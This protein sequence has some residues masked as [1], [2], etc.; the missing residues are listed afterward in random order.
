MAS[1]TS[2]DFE[3]EASVSW[4]LQSSVSFISYWL[5]FIRH[6]AS[7]L[8]LIA[9]RYE[10]FIDF[11]HNTGHGWYLSRYLS[12]KLPAL[13]DY[14]FWSLLTLSFYYS[15]E[16]SR[17]ELTIPWFRS[18]SSCRRTSIHLHEMPRRDISACISV[19]S[20]LFVASFSASI[21]YTVESK[22]LS[23]ILRQFILVEE[24]AVIIS[25]QFAFPVIACVDISKCRFRW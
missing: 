3:N 22:I 18:L 5:I 12:S 4:F 11:I 25:P 16:A 9:S 10:L 13:A 6:A 8:H 21:D 2:R 7:L 23:V 20:A 17:D 15:F 19:T 1:A 14:C 24:R